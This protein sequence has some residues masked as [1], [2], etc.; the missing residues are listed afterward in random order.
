MA[1]LL[2]CPSTPKM[3]MR[4]MQHQKY[5]NPKFSSRACKVPLGKGNNIGLG[6]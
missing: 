2:I 4:C 1:K 3:G 5:G 6:F